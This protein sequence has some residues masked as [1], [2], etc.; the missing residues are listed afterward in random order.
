MNLFIVLLNK[1]KKTRDKMDIAKNQIVN[2]DKRHEI[3]INEK[4]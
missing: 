1:F 3:I 4:N 2:M